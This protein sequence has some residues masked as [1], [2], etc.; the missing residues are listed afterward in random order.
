MQ[1]LLSVH[2]V[3]NPQADCV[4]DTENRRERLTHQRRDESD[5][6]Y[7]NHVSGLPPTFVKFL[8]EFTEDR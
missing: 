4:Q 1:W 3:D 2:P 7:T 5:M 6:T 8:G